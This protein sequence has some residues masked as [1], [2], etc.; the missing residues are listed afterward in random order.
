M[1]CSKCGHEL[2]DSTKFCPKCGTQTKAATEAANEAASKVEEVATAPEENAV[3]ETAEAAVENTVDEAETSQT[4]STVVTDNASK[5]YNY[6]FNPAD[7]PE[8]TKTP[9]SKKGLFIRLGFTC[10]G[11][12]LSN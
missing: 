5:D 6:G 8:P 10:L 3:E 11:S 2:S 1:F 4:E 9:G 7:I 12:F